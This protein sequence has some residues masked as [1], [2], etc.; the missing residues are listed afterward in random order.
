[1]SNNFTPTT[2]PHPHTAPVNNP[3]TN[4]G[5]TC[6]YKLARHKHADVNNIK[7]QKLNF[8][9]SINSADFVQPYITMNTEE[10]FFNPSNAYVAPKN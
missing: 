5:C 6:K 3:A 9:S 10:E 4:P 8:I 7:I 1:M 2:P